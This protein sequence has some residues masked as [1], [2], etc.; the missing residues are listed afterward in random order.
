MEQETHEKGPTEAKEPQEEKKEHESTPRVAKKFMTN[1][2]TLLT[3]FVM[4][5]DFYLIGAGFTI[6]WIVPTI[7]AGMVLFYKFEESSKS[8][9]KYWPL[10]AIIFIILLGM[11]IRLTDYRW[12]YLRNIDSYA[13]MREMELIVDNGFLQTTDPLFFRS[14]YEQGL[15]SPLDFNPL[16]IF[17]APYQY[18]G[19]YSYIFATMFNPDLQLWQHL[20][21]LPPLIASL[22]AIPMYY[23]GKLLYDRRAGVMAALFYVFDISNI[24]R[25]LAGDPDTDAVVML[26][27]LIVMAFYLLMYK[28]IEIKKRIDRLSIVYAFFAGMS[29]ALWQNVWA[30]YWYIPWLLLGFLI[31]KTAVKIFDTK[32]ILK[33]IVAMKRYFIGFALVLLFYGLLNFPFF[34]TELV[35]S[36]VFGPFEYQEVKSEDNRAFPNV[37]V[38]VAELQESGDIVSIIRRTTV[39]DG[40]LLWISPFMLTLYSLIMLL[41]GYLFYGRKR[42]FDTF[43]ILTLWFVG[44]VLATFIAVRFTLLFSPPLALGTAILLSAMYGYASKFKK[45][46]KKDE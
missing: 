46:V 30:G 11:H 1:W 34:G 3:V 44:P 6:E 19:A 31:I 7:I 32:D 16:W 35:A 21:Y 9:K 15:V 36:T 10:I 38:S 8:L 41:V 45:E 33:G 17:R 23:I 2:P 39:V 24:S 22:S 40:I 25:S 42:Y 4:L 29:L 43:V 18:F 13:F 26:M 12:D 37:Y 20:I 14:E 27:P 5:L 28:R